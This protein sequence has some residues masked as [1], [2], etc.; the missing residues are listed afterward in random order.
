MQTRIRTEMPEGEVK[1]AFVDMHKKGNLV[2]P[3]DS[4]RVLLN[5]LVE[6]TYE[7]GAHIDYY[8]CLS[9]SG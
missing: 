8:D 9:A 5:L 2:N 7:N 4:A 3:L 1:D 6:D